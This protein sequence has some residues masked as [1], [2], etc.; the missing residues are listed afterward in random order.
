MLERSHGAGMATPVALMSA[1]VLVVAATAGCSSGGGDPTGSGPSPT[2]NYVSANGSIQVGGQMATM[3][4][5]IA[6]ANGTP[7]PQVA[8]GLLH[9][10]VN[11]FENLVGT[12][13]PESDGRVA[14]ASAPGVTAA[15][16]YL[17]T[18]KLEGSTISGS[19]SGGGINGTASVV[20]AASS[21]PIEGVVLLGPW[22]FDHEISVGTLVDGV[23]PCP[24]PTGSRIITDGCSDRYQIEVEGNMLPADS[25]T[26]SCLPDLD[27]AT[28]SLNGSKLTL[29]IPKLGEPTT[30]PNRL[31]SVEISGCTLIWTGQ[32]ELDVATGRAL[33]VNLV[34]ECQGSE[35][36]CD[37]FCT[38]GRLSSACV[39]NYELDLTRCTGECE[40]PS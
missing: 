15:T 13:V 1:A 27:L 21:V 39:V 7:A 3:M 23:D 2:G 24:V 11:D 38:N 33:P 14:L 9:I 26:D 30:P 37:P 6:S 40:C 17:F 28:G 20:L 32:I 25:C 5:N 18:G 29:Q 8:R 22:N 19:L 35:G 31:F 4:V 34:S 16:P 36:A 12:Y 10:G